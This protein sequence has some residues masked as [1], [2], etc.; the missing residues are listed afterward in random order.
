MN[1]CQYFHGIGLVLSLFTSLR[2]HSFST[3][4]SSRTLVVHSVKY[5]K[6]TLQ[7]ILGKVHWKCFSQL[8]ENQE[9]AFLVCTC[10][11]LVPFLLFYTACLLLSTSYRSL[12]QVLVE[13]YRWDHEV[14]EN[15]SSF[16]R[17]MLEYDPAWRATAKQCLKHPWLLWRN[18]QPDVPL[19]CIHVTISRRNFIVV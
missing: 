2:I 10:T 16:L 17:P 7:A 11:L 19:H 9:Y 18:K 14:A 3:V 12:T 15:L 5:T 13:K 8:C 1:T 6:E 4:S